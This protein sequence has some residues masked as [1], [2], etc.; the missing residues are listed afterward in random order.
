MLCVTYIASALLRNETARSIQPEVHVS[1]VSRDITWLCIGGGDI[2]I[3]MEAA[4][5]LRDSDFDTLRIIVY[6]H[7]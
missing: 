2:A 4:L 6:D 7:F 1:E 3:G 5:L